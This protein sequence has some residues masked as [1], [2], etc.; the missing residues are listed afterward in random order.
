MPKRPGPIPPTPAFSISRQFTGPPFSVMLESAELHRHL[1]EELAH[2]HD[3]KS[4][5]AEPA[6]TAAPARPAAR[7]RA[8]AKPRAKKSRK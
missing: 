4:V 2:P 3:G 7:G 5:P 8:P 6:K 1:M